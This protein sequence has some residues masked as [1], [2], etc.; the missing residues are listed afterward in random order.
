MCFSPEA[1]FTASAVITTIGVISLK[2]ATDNPSKFLAYIPIFFGIQ[3][4]AEGFVWLSLLYDSFAHF[5]GM[6]TAG[7]IFFAWVV[8]PFWIPF[9]MGK[10]EQDVARKR[11]L[12]VFKYIGVLVS[13]L[14]AYVVVFENVNSE[15]L[16]W[17]IIYNFDVSDG[18]HKAFGLLYLS[19]TVIPTLISKVP[20][21]WLLGVMNVL[22]Y[23]GTKI[24]INER[25]L[26]IWCFFAAITSV[27]VLWIIED[28]NK[29]KA[30]ENKIQA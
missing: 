20:K 25:I 17:S 6:S 15:I 4:F 11:I 12:N 27:I 7:F 1:S 26:S 5:R 14:L 13:L 29:R 10:I 21:V 30:I 28:Y 24:F 23:A 16:D 2:R 19:I 18:L 9:A 8:W 3:Q 22:A